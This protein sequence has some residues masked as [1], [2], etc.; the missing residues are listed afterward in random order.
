MPLYSKKQAAYMFAN[1]PTIAKKMADAMKSKGNKHPL[2]K[3][4]AVSRT[5]AARQRHARRIRRGK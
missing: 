4:P 2:K 1:H 3:L 5:K